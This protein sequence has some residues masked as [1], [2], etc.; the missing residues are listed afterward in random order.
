[1]I[2]ITENAK[3]YLKTKVKNQDYITLGVQGGGC[4][5]FTYVWDVKS[6]WPDVKWGPVMDDVL[7][8]DPLAEIFIAGCEIDYVDE[9][10]GAYLKI[11]N[12]NATASCGCGESFSI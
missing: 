8:L 6:K 7:V 2:T 4:S 1:M 9:L 12:P 10:G 11:N 3:T 5:G